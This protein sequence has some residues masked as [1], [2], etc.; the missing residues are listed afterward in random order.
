MDVADTSRHSADSI[1]SDDTEYLL[2]QNVS[3]REIEDDD[4]PVHEHGKINSFFGRSQHMS[5]QRSPKKPQQVNSKNVISSSKKDVKIKT[6]RGQDEYHRS[7]SPSIDK[8]LSSMEPQ[9]NKVKGKKSKGPREFISNELSRE[10]SEMVQNSYRSKGVWQSQ[11]LEGA[12][13]SSRS[14]SDSYAKHT[15]IQ[16]NFQSPESHKSVHVQSQHMVTG[17]PKLR[18][19]LHYDHPS[20]LTPPTR[21]RQNTKIRPTEP[22]RLPVRQNLPVVQD[23]WEIDSQIS[24]DTLNGG[25]NVEVESNDL[26]SQVSEATEDLMRGED[27]DDEDITDKLKELNLAVNYDTNT[28][29]KY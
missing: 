12:P 14:N 4:L 27:E 22:A 25:N 18:P 17:S 15:H 8:H 2:G 20:R 19:E 16:G 28:N 24:L 6:V 3:I 23:N 10:H 1:C 11:E 29:G 7:P 13:K 9:M 21:E 26:E 5:P